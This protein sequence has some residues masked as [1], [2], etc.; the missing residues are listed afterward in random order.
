MNANDLRRKFQSIHKDLYRSIPIKNEK[1]FIIL[2]ISTSQAFREVRSI[3]SDDV[4]VTTL[5]CLKRLFHPH[6]LLLIR[7]SYAYRNK[8]KLFSLFLN[9]CSFILSSFLS[10][11]RILLSP[12]HVVM[13][14]MPMHILLYNKIG[15]RKNCNRIFTEH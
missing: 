2:Q 15:T 1:P 14:S 6:P 3:I 11:S 7:Y 4:C 5:H 10:T 8:K 13:P 12:L 9:C